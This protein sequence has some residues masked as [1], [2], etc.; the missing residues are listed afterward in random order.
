MNALKRISDPVKELAIYK[1]RNV[2]IGAIQG[3]M[4]AAAAQYTWLRKQHP[5]FTHSWS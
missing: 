4:M 2:S 1:I 3:E 5:D